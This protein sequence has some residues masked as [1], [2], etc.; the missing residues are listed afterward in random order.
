MHSSLEPHFENRHT[1]FPRCA[2][3]GQ[4]CWSA[5]PI[6]IIAFARIESTRHI[7]VPAGE[8]WRRVEEMAVIDWL[9]KRCRHRRLLGSFLCHRQYGAN[10]RRLDV[11]SV[12][13]ITSRLA[14]ASTADAGIDALVET[15]VSEIE[16]STPSLPQT[17]AGRRWSDKYYECNAILQI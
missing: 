16:L 13:C 6:S 11:A 15:R 5:A 2:A 17:L 10:P 1:A 3:A 12:R 14:A 7:V 9:R 4:G 8:P